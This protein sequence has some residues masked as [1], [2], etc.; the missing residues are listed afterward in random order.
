MNPTLTLTIAALL[1]SPIALAQPAAATQA[2]DGNAAIH[3]VNITVVDRTYKATWTPWDGCADATITIA[4]HD[5]A[6]LTWDPTERQ[7]LIASHTVKAS[8]GELEWSLPA[9][10]DPRCRLQLDLVTG[11]P[12]PEVNPTSRYNETA[13][14]GTR[15]RLID[16]RYT[17]AP[18]KVEATPTPLPP[19]PVD[20]QPPVTQPP[21]VDEPELSTP[22]T[23]EG[24]APP[25]TVPPV[26]STSPPGAGDSS[27]KVPFRSTPWT[28]E[29]TPP[30][31]PETG[32]PSAD[33]ART[34]LLVGFLGG[35]F[36]V[37]AAAYTPLR[38]R[39]R[40]HV[41]THQERKFDAS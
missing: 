14:G 30:R 28:L 37:L 13:I 18:C 41:P 31:L 11:A 39:M 25:S 29:Q 2:C 36:C 17:N 7:P 22:T 35:V 40:Q 4:A 1:A 19:Q 5:T 38:R 27:V 21:V 12:L 26:S 34:G 32:G 23:P 16:A 24:T 33:I 20:P 3:N 15:N 10:V 9:G 8:A 6:H